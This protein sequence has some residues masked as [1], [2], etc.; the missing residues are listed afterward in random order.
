MKKIS[1]GQ[2]VTKAQAYGKPVHD[3]S[4]LKK[5]LKEKGYTYDEPKTEKDVITLAV[6]SVL[7]LL[8]GVNRLSWGMTVSEQSERLSREILAGAYYQQSRAG[9]DFATLPGKSGKVSTDGDDLVSAW[10]CGYYDALAARKGHQEAMTCARREVY[11]ALEDDKKARASRQRTTVMVEYDDYDGDGHPIVK[12]EYVK[13]RVWV[14]HAHVMW[15][16]DDDGGWTLSYYDKELQ[17]LLNDKKSAFNFVYER[18]YKA[19]KTKN[20]RYILNLYLENYTPPQI[21]QKIGYH[22]RTIYKVLERIF[23]KAKKIRSE[24]PE[25]F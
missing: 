18:V 20:E 16:D 6:K 4:R 1:K 17:E 2:A 24:N 5:Y 21:A 13:K 19:L 14:P 22:E 11:R 7:A 15:C 8:A 12:R 10:I 25:I 23:I 9:E 3:F